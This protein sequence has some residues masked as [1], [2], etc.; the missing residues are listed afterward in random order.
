MSIAH[1]TF[2]LARR[3]LQDPLDGLKSIAILLNL[4]FP[5]FV[6]ESGRNTQYFFHLIPAPVH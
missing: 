3:T 5:F 6:M 1:G 2:V 4:C